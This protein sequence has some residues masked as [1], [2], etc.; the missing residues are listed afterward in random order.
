MNIEKI[1]KELENKQIECLC[2]DT[3]GNLVKGLGIVCGY[4]ESWLVLGFNTD[5]EGCIKE[6]TKSVNYSQNFRSYRF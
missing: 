4:K 5:Y 6:F 2:N 1:Y 3:N